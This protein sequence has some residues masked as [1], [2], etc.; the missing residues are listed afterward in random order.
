M[1]IRR[2]D[3]VLVVRGK[4]KGKRGRVLTVRPETSRLLIEG[5][6]LVK[7]HIK[8]N[9]NLR[10]AGIVERPAALAVANVR[11]LCTKCGK[12]ARVGFRL[13][14]KQEGVREKTEKVRVCKKCN[15]QID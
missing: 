7:R 11:L 14:P 6:N 10:Q 3:M 12:P 15:D 9:P 13:L 4:D 1:K 8:A 2:N 5:V